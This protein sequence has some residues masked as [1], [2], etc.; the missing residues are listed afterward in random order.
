MLKISSRK[1]I[2]FYTLKIESNN[3]LDSNFITAL[4]WV[5][6]YIN[7][8]KVKLSYIRLTYLTY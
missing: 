2:E 4:I 8:S 6:F 3:I 7:L 5:N 1:K